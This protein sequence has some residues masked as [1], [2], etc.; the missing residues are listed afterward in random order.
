MGY[1]V[2]KFCETMVVDGCDL[3]VSAIR[4]AG[5][6]DPIVFLHGFGSTKE[7]YADLTLHTDFDD[8]PFLAY[9]APGCGETVCGDCAKV[10]IPFLVETARTML[11][12]CGI[13]R[14][15]LV[16]HSMGGSQL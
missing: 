13:A 3:N 6:K 14:F 10:S 15:H 9:D 1:D 8:R 2:Q 11:D 4:R 12:R 5:S 7:D 16:G